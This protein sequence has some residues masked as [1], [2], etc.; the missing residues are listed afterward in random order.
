MSLGI[1]PQKEVSIGESWEDETA[2]SDIV[3][4]QIKTKF[5][6]EKADDAFY[7]IKSES[8]L[9]SKNAALEAGGISM[10]YD[11]SGTMTAAYLINKKS[12]WSKETKVEQE[13]SGKITFAKND[14]LPDGMTIPM[15][16]KSS[17]MFTE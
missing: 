13:I 1:F 15:T 4:M 5:T 6:L 11:L 10:N 2:V 7:Y 14:K 9:V 16:V 12:G 8:T 3:S 17:M